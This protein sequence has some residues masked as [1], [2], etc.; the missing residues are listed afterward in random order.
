[1]GVDRW[2]GGERK[3]Q[4]IDITKLIQ[5]WRNGAL[6]E[7]A[8]DELQGLVKACCSTDRVGTFTLKLRIEPKPSKSG[9]YTVQITPTVDA[10]NPRFDTG[11]GIF[12]VVTD[13]ENLP[14]GLELED[15]RQ[16]RLF[17]E[18]TVTNHD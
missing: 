2:R 11:I 7:E 14:V 12:H 18:A 5:E 10:K 9:G 4:M 15:P 8:N 13:D 16:T 1:M 17:M 6:L 3:V